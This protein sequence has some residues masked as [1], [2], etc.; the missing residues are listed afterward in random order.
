VAF[1]GDADRAGFLDEKGQVIPMDMITSLIAQAILRKNKGA[2]IF[3]DLRSSWAVKETIEQNGGRP[4]MSR[5]GHAFIKQ[6]MRDAD[7]CLRG[8]FPAIII[9]RKI[10]IPKAPPWRPLWVANLVSQSDQPCRK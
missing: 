8:S 10:S 7:A 9:S 3:Y 2:A 4:M 1:D 5:V 6:Q